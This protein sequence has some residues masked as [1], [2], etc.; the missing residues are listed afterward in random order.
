MPKASREM[1]PACGEPFKGAISKE[2]VSTF[3]VPGVYGVKC[4]PHVGMGMV[5]L[6]E[7]DIASAT[8]RA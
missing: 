4:M 5:A 6:T 3:T 1:V 8:G 2:V 7:S